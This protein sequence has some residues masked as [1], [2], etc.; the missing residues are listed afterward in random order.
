MTIASAFQISVTKI[1]DG[2]PVDFPRITVCDDLPLLAKSIIED[3]KT[4][5]RSSVEEYNKALLPSSF[6]QR[7]G[8]FDLLAMT[9]KAE[10]FD[11]SVNDIFAYAATPKGAKEVITLSMN[12]AGADASP[13]IQKMDAV[14][15]IKLANELIIC[16]AKEEAPTQFPLA[17]TA[18]GSS[19]DEKPL[20]APDPYASYPA[21]SDG[22]GNA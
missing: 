12:K 17:P 5:V 19:P 4:K 20:K 21:K 1:V 8:A 13:I 7:I 3:R 11:P 22:N 6:N 2:K 16:T 9:Q 15:F 10:E 18:D 14:T